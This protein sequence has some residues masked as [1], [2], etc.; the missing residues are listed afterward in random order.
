MDQQER[1]CKSILV[2]MGGKKFY[3]TYL[4][5]NKHHDDYPNVA[6]YEKLVDE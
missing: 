6:G 4:E 1:T 2:T 5:F 3:E